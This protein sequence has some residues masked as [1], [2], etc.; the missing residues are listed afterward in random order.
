MSDERAHPFP[1]LDEALMSS[2]PI[3]EF[4][5]WYERAREAGVRDPDAMAIAT[6]DA[7]ARPSARMVLLRGIDERGFFFNTN[8]ESRKGSELLANPHAALLWYWPELDCQVRIEGPVERVTERESD[9]YF[10][11]RPRESRLAAWASPQSRVLPDRQTLERRYAEL[12]ESY[13]DRDVPRPPTWG[14]FRLR[15]QTLE[16]WQGRPHRLHDRIRYR[17]VAGAWVRERLGP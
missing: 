15:P 4:R 10:R 17:L 14:G 3:A 9:D 5:A 7:D 8:Y 16:F 13:R 1:G 11:L 12:A 2:D 6:A